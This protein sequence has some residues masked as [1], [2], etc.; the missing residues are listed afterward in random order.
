M[1]KKMERGLFGEAAG[2]SNLLENPLRR[3]RKQMV[4]IML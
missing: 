4:Q 1:A 2:Y 3:Q